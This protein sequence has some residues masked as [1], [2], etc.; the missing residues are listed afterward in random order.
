MGRDVGHIAL[1]A[2]VGAGA[3]RDFDSQRKTLVLERYWNL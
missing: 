2:G 1:N 3:E